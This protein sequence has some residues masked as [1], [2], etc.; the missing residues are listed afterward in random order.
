MADAKSTKHNNLFL[1]L[2]LPTVRTRMSIPVIQSAI[3]A[4]SQ[5]IKCFKTPSFEC[6]RTELFPPGFNQVQPASILGDELHL[7]FRPSG[8]SKSGL[9]TMMDAQVVLNNHPT[10]SRKNLHHQTQQLN[11]TD[12]IPT[13]TH[14]NSCLPRGRLESSMN[15]E[16]AAPSIVRFK[17]GPITT[18]LPFFSW[19]C[20]N[21]QGTQ[22][23]NTNHTCSSRRGYVR[24]N[25]GPLFST[26][27][28]SCCAESW[29][30]LCWRFHLK[31]SSS[32][33]VQMVESDKWTSWRSLNARCSRSSVHNSNGYSSD[34]GF[35]RA[36]LINALRTSWLWVGLRPGRGRSSN[37][38][39]P[40]SLNRL[41]HVTPMTSLLYPARRP[42][43]DAASFG[44]SSIAAIIC[45]RCTWR[46]G[47][48]R[49]A[50]RRRI[51]A[52]SSVVN[53]LNRIRFGILPPLSLG[54]II[55]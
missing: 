40:C 28:G 49:D 33:Q 7:D 48:V 37:P 50:A 30:Q 54:R 42:A 47:F 43:A 8:Q 11:M 35:C 45:A 51:S 2:L 13:R 36:K 12:A 6:Q 1:R 55:P 22:F 10:V 5:F 44:S 25:Y 15:P 9:T 14:H 24:L 4:L 29:N 21:R 34:R 26:N 41:T 46:I 39:S 27:S 53:C 52:V 19:I 31:P 17:R 3:Q 23:V 38:A 20:L 18:W 16:F 32:I